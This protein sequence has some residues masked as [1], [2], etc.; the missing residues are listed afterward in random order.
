MRILSTFHDYYDGVQAHGQDGGLQYVRKVV[1]EDLGAKWPWPWIIPHSERA[2]RIK[3]HVIGFCGKIYPV[4]HLSTFG[5]D[6]KEAYCYNVDEVDA[7]VLPL[8]KKK[9]LEVYLDEKKWYYTGFHVAQRRKQFRSF[10]EAFAEIGDKQQWRFEKN[11]SPI[12]VAS[13]KGRAYH[14]GSEE[15]A[16]PGQKIEWNGQLRGFGFVRVKEPYTAYQEI[17][18][19]LGNMAFPNKP[20]PAISDEIMAEIKG[21]NKYSFRKDKAS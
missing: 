17:S 7:F 3:N 21:F 16:D 1:E 19:F 4:L 6:G 12:F 5:T 20:I 8:L 18:M 11:L 15:R 9:A 13:L 14:Y 2:F 10:F